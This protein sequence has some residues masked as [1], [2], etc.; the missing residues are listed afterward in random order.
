MNEHHV[1]IT[2]RNELTYDGM[3]D[4]MKVD[5]STGF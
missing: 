5:L 3:V 1:G 4:V 2:K